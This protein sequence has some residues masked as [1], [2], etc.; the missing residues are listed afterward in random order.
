MS[1]PPPTPK[2]AHLIWLALTGLAIAFIVA[3]VV[4]LVWGMGQV[5]S[6]LGPVL[7]PIA[8]AGVLAYLLDPVVDFL[9]RKRVP[10]TRAISMVFFCAVMLLLAL[11]G[12]IVPQLVSETRDLVVRIPDYVQRTQ[13]SVV[14]WVKNPPAPLR[15]FLDKRW[16]GDLGTNPP[17]ATNLVVETTNAQSKGTHLIATTGSTTNAPFHWGQ[18]FE[19]KAIGSAAHWLG[20]KLGEVGKWLAGKLS[21][22]AGIFGVFVGLALVPVYLFYLLLEK[23]GIESKWSDYLPLANSNLKNE[24][25]FVIRAINGYLIVFFRGQV[26]VAICDGITYTIGFLIIGLPYAILLGVMATG[27]T[28][29]P[30]L[31][32]I[33]TCAAALL[34]ALVQ[35][36]DW[37]HPLLVLAVFGVVQTL[38]G[39]VFQPKIL[40]DRVGLHPLTIIIAVMIGTTVLGGIL[41]GILAIPLTAAGKVLMERYVWKKEAQTKA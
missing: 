36:G 32:A 30:F 15:D 1:L 3:L 29:I 34:I 22:V 12:S 27:L 24:L 17:P 26:L 35:F 31:G 2:Q 7:W 16:H 18:L 8:L 6:L 28:M 38:E 23:R 4:A 37:Q 40:G 10:R 13:T 33:A 39:L 14:N 41:G 20:P 21:K 11:L 5:L 25:V 9:E 19:E